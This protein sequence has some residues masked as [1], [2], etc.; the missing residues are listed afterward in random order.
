MIKMWKRFRDWLIRKLGGV[1]Q[2]EIAAAVDDWTDE[3]NA[4]KDH[5]AR[6]ELERNLA[7][8]KVEVLQEENGRLKME[9]DRDSPAWKMLHSMTLYPETLQAEWIYRSDPE[10]AIDMD[11]VAKERVTLQIL[12]GVREKIHYSFLHDFFGGSRVRATLRI[13]EGTGAVDE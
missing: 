12:D 3:V 1:T 7:R 9:L 8:K 6:L 13:L 10:S 5:A 4:V 2:E 11:K